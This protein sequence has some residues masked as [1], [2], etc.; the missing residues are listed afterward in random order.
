[1]AFESG[2][3]GLLIGLILGFVLMAAGYITASMAKDQLLN[4][5]EILIR[6]QD[7]MISNMAKVIDK[8]E[9]KR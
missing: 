1:M 8:Y 6:K 7:L 2:Y 4:E 3:I 5:K 9:N